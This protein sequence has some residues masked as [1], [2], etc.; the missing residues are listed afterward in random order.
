MPQCVR[1]NLFDT[2]IMELALINLENTQHIDVDKSQN[3]VQ[4]SE[5]S[6]ANILFQDTSLGNIHCSHLSTPN[7]SLFHGAIHMKKS[8]KLK[9]LASPNSLNVCVLLEGC[10]ETNFHSHSESLQLY[11]NSHNSIHLIEHEGDHLLPKGE[12]K[13]FHLNIDSE[14]FL[15]QFSSEDK[16]AD[17]FKNSILKSAVSVAS[18]QPGYIYPEMRS[19]IKAIMNNPYKDGLKKMYLE[20]KTFE[21]L[22]LQFLQFGDSIKNDTLL[23]RKEKQIAAEVRMLLDENM[24][25][26]WTLDELAQKTGSNIQT[27]KKS[28]KGLYNTNVFNY[29]QQLRM[30]YARHLLLDLDITVAEVSD[31]LGYSHQNH[32]SSAFKKC[33]GFP[34]SELKAK[35]S[36]VVLIKG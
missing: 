15:Q 26:P 36:R 13:L 10:I 31:M 14:Y 34:P 18:Q 6:E 30:D 28:F 33:F 7:I 11:N 20:I 25:H 5:I 19:I 9:T 8:I 17:R 23:S 32:F 24:L 1:L 4:G 21:L 2:H 22:I 16:V 29:Y 35:S 12:I 27:V 3:T